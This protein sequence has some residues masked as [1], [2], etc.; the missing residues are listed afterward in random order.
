MIK[1]HYIVI[2]LN[3]FRN[4]FLINLILIIIIGF[5]SFKFHK[6]LARPWDISTPVPRQQPN[7]KSVLE[8]K[9][10][11]IE[12][13]D[14]DSAVYNVI[15]Q[16]DL[17]RPSRSASSANEASIGLSPKETP[18]LFGTIITEN[19]R[20]AILEDPST[21]MTKQYKIDDLFAGFI[22][23]DIQKDKVILLKEGESVEVELREIKTIKLLPQQPLV[24]PSKNNNEIRDTC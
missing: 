11:V 4:Y 17:F 20:S 24:R 23:S 10:T 18:K 2:L 13:S 8:K 6:A 3:M 15:V 5:L 14:I 9:L 19:G 22:V 7:I 16:K 12:E 1:K 21:K